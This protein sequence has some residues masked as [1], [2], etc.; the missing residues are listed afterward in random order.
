[1]RRCS[2]V[3]AC[4]DRFDGSPHELWIAN[5][6]IFFFQQCQMSPCIIFLEDGN[7][8]RIAILLEIPKGPHGPLACHSRNFFNDITMRQLIFETSQ[9]GCVISV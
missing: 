4:W 5:P 3:G 7:V 8:S 1:M 9:A 2:S 6:P